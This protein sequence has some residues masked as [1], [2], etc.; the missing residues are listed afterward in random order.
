MCFTAG[1]AA[2]AQT[3][4]SGRA[5]AGAGRGICGRGRSSMADDALRLLHKMIGDL[6]GYIGRRASELAAP[7]IEQARAEARAEIAEA[8]AQNQ[9]ITD[10]AEELK[11]RMGPLQQRSDES[12]AACGR[13]AAALGHDPW[14]CTLDVLV[15][16]AEAALADAKAA[17]HG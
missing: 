13:L 6:D 11:R 12:R 3:A 4:T 15:A 14:G 9:R 2:I 16:E 17:S 10:L 7:L 1:T 5:S 8:V